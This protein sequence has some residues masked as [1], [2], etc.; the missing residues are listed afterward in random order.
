MGFD[1]V[2]R[3]NSNLLKKE[4]TKMVTSSMI[5]VGSLQ[6]FILNEKY[7][8]VQYLFSFLL[9]RELR[10]AFF[11]EVGYAF[12]EIVAAQAGEHFVVGY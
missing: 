2:L 8:L 6:S 1:D 7:T 4:A 5:H 12:F 9:A 11:D 3:H 10:G